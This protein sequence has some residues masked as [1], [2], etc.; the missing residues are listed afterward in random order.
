MYIFMIFSRLRHVN[1]LNM[2][3]RNVQMECFPKS[4]MMEREYKYTSKET[5]LDIIPD[6][7]S[8]LCLTRYDYCIMTSFIVQYLSQSVSQSPRI[9]YLHANIY[10]NK[11][12]QWISISKFSSRRFMILTGFTLQR[13]YSS[14][15]STWKWFNFRCWSAAYWPENW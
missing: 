4:N 15:F 12:H 5:S 9:D 10:L 13:F 8:P 1:L 3:W 6:L 7:L 2:L 14:S 11:T